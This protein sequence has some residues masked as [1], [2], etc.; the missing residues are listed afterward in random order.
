MRDQIVLDVLLAVVE[1]HA[2][3][4]ACYFTGREYGR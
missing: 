4:A 2:T 3:R 1:M